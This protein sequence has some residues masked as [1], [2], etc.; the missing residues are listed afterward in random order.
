MKKLRDKND[1]KIKYRPSIQINFAS[2]K[3]LIPFQ[4]EEIYNACR[5]NTIKNWKDR[6]TRR[7]VESTIQSEYQGVSLLQGGHFL[8]LLHFTPICSCT[9]EVEG[10]WKWETLQQSSQKTQ[11][12]NAVLI[13]LA[14]FWTNISI[15][16]KLILILRKLAVLLMLRPVKLNCLLKVMSVRLSPIW[17]KQ[18]PKKNMLIKNK[19]NQSL[20]SKTRLHLWMQ[21]KHS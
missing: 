18:P 9:A 15:M 4:W 1:I 16:M 21:D 20:N 2:E 17:P 11:G 6:P 10:T 8:F 3:H 19:M 13:T 5:K 14:L 12:L 7:V